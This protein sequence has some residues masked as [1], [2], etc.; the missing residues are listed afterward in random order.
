MNREMLLPDL[1]F[2][3]AGFAIDL[4]FIF[5]ALRLRRKRAAPLDWAVLFLLGLLAGLILVGAFTILF[6]DRFF[7]VWRYRGFA[8]F[9]HGPIALAGFAWAVR[10]WRRVAIPLA[11]A[12]AALFAVY[13]DAYHI[14]PRRLVVS[15]F[16]LAHERL[17]GLQ[18]PV[19]IAQVADIQ[20]D[21]VGPR[22]RRLFAEIKRLNPDMIVYCGDY[23]HTWT[24]TRHDELAAELNAVVRAADLRPPLGSYAVSG[25]VDA[26][27]IWPKVFEGTD[28]KILDNKAVVIDLPGC[29]ANL[30]GLDVARSRDI[31]GRHLPAI[32][33]PRAP[34]LFDLYLA[35]APD[36]VRALAD[37]PDPFL[38]LCGHTHGGQVNV[39]FFGPPLVLMS[40]PRKY[41]DYFGPY[42]S[43][44]LSVCRGIGLERVDAPRLRFNCPPE[45]RLVTLRPPE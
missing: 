45:L 17:R 24:D 26:P 2:N 37:G 15:R 4:A 33:A 12:A 9:W 11:L 40:L 19:L 44:T 22:E 38:Y 13:I 43:G 23:L 41:A 29:K 3:I 42:G 7:A 6:H 14:E 28:V 39:P 27:A 34:G 25:D 16:D 31:A 30:I 21:V 20:T 32:L 1:A 8:L 10:E 36:A 35:H 18:R 5:A